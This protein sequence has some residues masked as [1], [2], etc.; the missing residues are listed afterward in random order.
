[1]FI[2]N[3][4]IESVT[5][6]FSLPSSVILSLVTMDIFVKMKQSTVFF[7]AF[8][9]F[10]VFFFFAF[11]SPQRADSVILNHLFDNVIT[12]SLCSAWSLMEKHAAVL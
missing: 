12:L 2:D 7:A 9:I 8:A 11:S 4:I 6:I 5:L 10:Q 3:G 1:M